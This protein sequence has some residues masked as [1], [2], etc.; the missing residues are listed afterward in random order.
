MATALGPAPTSLQHPKDSFRP[1][2]PQGR[3]LEKES[4]L[5]RVGT[6]A[7]GHQVFPERW[8]ERGRAR[9]RCSSLHLGESQPGLKDPNKQLIMMLTVYTGAGRQGQ[10]DPA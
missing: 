8:G 1:R 4:L 2:E 3:L 10:G 5:K 6:L 7:G 9:R